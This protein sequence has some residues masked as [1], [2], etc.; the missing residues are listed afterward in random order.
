MEKSL[1][2]KWT[3]ALQATGQ[4]LSF[5][6]Q[7]SF[8]S[9]GSELRQHNRS[10][11]GS[12]YTPNGVP[13]C[14]WNS[15]EQGQRGPGPPHC[16][17]QRDVLEPSERH[18]LRRAPEGLT[19]P[20]SPLFYEMCIK[21]SSHEGLNILFMHTKHF[22]YAHQGLPSLVAQM[23]KNL[24]IMQETRGFIPGWGRSP[25]EGNG[26]PLQ[27]SCLGNSMDRGAWRAT[28]HG[29]GKSRT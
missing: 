12:G 15:Q 11:K 19:H 8:I 27:Y 25:G 17:L 24:P 28:V 13:W 16:V 4:S 18:V 2:L 9:S 7:K 5:Q 21:A 14:E 29:V 1:L 23:I 20:S 6:L 22:L 26:Y 10:V 3:S